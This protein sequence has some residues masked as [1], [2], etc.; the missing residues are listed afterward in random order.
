MREH[1]LAATP[2]SLQAARPAGLCAPQ[3]LVPR[4]RHRASWE[5][6]GETAQSPTEP[7]EQARRPLGRRREAG[8]DSPPSRSTQTRAAPRI[9][10]VSAP[11]SQ[12]RGGDSPAQHI[13]A[14]EQQQAQE[15]NQ[16][17]L[18]VKPWEEKQPRL[19]ETLAGR[20]RRE[21][22]PNTLTTSG[23][24]RC[25]GQASDQRPMSATLCPPFCALGD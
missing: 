20:P 5:R 22:H 9:Q 24:R 13:P 23:E 3:H 11:G 16:E 14:E 7:P 15:E 17:Q 4:K 25:P 19:G 18:R 8:G 21:L 2:R 12:G 6:G 10:H 1:P